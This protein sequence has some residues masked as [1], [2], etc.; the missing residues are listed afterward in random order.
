M[1]EFAWPFLEIREHDVPW[2]T[3]TQTKVVELVR[4]HLGYG[5][6]TDELCRQHPHLS[7]AQV[8]SALAYYYAHKEVIEQDIQR[9]D[10]WVE[11]L[12]QEFQDPGLVARIVEAKARQ[13][14]LETDI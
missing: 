10:C 8:H 13:S 4:E 3:G 14:A 9:R 2:I 5:W 6:Q 11:E 7:L 12:K 1:P